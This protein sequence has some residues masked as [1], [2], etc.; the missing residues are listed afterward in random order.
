MF[1]ASFG[2]SFLALLGSV[3]A[4]LTVRERGKCLFQAFEGDLKN[5][6][7]H[8]WGY[9]QIIYFNGMFMDFPLQNGCFRL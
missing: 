2:G 5:G 9:P 7:F 3:I 6:G 8:K 4:T 1:G